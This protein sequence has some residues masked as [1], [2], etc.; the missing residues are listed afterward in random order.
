[1]ADTSETIPAA[2]PAAEP[3]EPKPYDYRD[4]SQ[5]APLNMDIRD[6]DYFESFKNP[7]THHFEFS[8]DEMMI[9]G[10]ALSNLVGA[11]WIFSPKDTIDDDIRASWQALQFLKKINATLPEDQRMGCICE[12]LL[13]FSGGDVYIDAAYRLQTKEVGTAVTIACFDYEKGGVKFR[14]FDPVKYPNAKSLH[15]CLGETVP[16]DDIEGIEEVESLTEAEK[17]G[18]ALA[19]RN[20]WE[21]FY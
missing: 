3:A 19:I 17:E 16:L 14:L 6:N 8:D 2:A 18:F 13:P 21:N 11:S 9:L 7:S 1:M 12:S 15:E 20:A 4:L 10:N 5:D